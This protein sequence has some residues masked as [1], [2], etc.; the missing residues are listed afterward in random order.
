MKYT[1]LE[2]RSTDMQFNK[3]TYIPR[4]TVDLFHYLGNLSD[5]D[6]SGRAVTANGGMSYC[7]VRDN[8]TEQWGIEIRKGR[9]SWDPPNTVTPF[10]SRATA[11]H[12]FLAQANTPGLHHQDLL[13]WHELITWAEEQGYDKDEYLHHEGYSAFGSAAPV[14]DTGVRWIACWWTPGDSEGYYVHVAQVRI[15]PL[16]KA[17]T[18]RNCLT[19]K[20][21]SAPQA[22][23]VA[24]NLQWKVCQHHG[25]GDRELSEITHIS[26][27]AHRPKR[28][29]D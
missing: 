22:A 28:K 13:S 12:A 14:Y 23:L 21:W 24:T 2:S 8:K 18:L 6:L 10:P 15:D 29:E 5:D 17:T 26:L 3:T 11:Q 25:C 7:I 19:V 9:Y 27:R 4:L 1:V 16:S 20:V